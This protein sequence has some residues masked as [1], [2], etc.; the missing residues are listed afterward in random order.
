MIKAS[1]IFILCLISFTIASTTFAKDKK[2]H[3][4]QAS[5][6]P[7]VAVHDR[8]QTIEGFT[9]SLWGEN[10]QRA[11]SLGVINGSKGDSAGA[12]FGF[13]NYGDSYKG[14]QFGFINADDVMNGAQFGFLN[15]TKKTDTGIQF[16]FLNFI[17]ENKRWFKISRISLRL[18]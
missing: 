1:K 2:S 4:F 17:K 5:L 14:A 18:L 3:P 15:F 9:I 13:I 12:S 8:D 16:G 7:G 6:T 10:L 11:L